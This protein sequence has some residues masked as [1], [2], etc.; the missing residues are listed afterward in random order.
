MK[1]IPGVKK[2]SILDLPRKK[3]K[4][5]LKVLREAIKQTDSFLIPAMILETGG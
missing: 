2:L 4:F 5:A 3:K 1:K